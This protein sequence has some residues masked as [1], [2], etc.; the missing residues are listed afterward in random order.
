MKHQ[1]IRAEWLAKTKLYKKEKS[2]TD[3]IEDA[4]RWDLRHM[5]VMQVHTRA[6]G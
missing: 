1:E 3:D 6:M 5:Q 4:K 2:A